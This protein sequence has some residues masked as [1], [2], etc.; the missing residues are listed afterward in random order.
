MKRGCNMGEVVRRG[1]VP[2][3]SKE[4]NEAA[5]QILNN[6][7]EDLYYLLNRNYKIKGA[8]TLIGNHYMLSERQRL[9][10]VRAISSQADLEIRKM[11]ECQSPIEEVNI[12]G[13]NTII[14]LEVALSESLLVK[15]MDGT[16]RDLAGLRGTYRLI[17]K[18]RIAIQYLL[19]TLEEKGIKKAHIFLDAPVS[20]SGRL[21]QLI[22]EMSEAYPLEVRVEVINEVDAVLSG[23]KGVVSSDAIILNKCESWINLNASIIEEKIPSSWCI[24]FCN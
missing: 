6:A 2:S 23:L 11:K 18:T 10:L 20:N 7:G 22:L 21:K 3:D 12:D 4:F 15:G 17:D 1:Y 8:S 19:E 24:D 16:I 14:T 9:A 5:L 13:F